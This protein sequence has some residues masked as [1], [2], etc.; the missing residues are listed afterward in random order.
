MCVYSLIALVGHMQ[1]VV[2]ERPVNVFER[3]SGDQKKVAGLRERVGQL[4]QKHEDTGATLDT[5]DARLTPIE[6]VLRRWAIQGLEGGDGTAEAAQT[7]DQLAAIEREIDRVDSDVAGWET[8]E[9]PVP[10]P[11]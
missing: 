9:N 10:M 5:L 4:E 7:L 3:Y 6:P 1:D 8:E 2:G 11:M